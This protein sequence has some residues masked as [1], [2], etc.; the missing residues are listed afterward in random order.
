MRCVRK[1]GVVVGSDLGRPSFLYSHF[2]AAVYSCACTITNFSR[3]EN[4]IL[5]LLH[6]FFQ[7]LETFVPW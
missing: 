2:V 7:A 5:S 6:V 4:A 1:Y 3:H